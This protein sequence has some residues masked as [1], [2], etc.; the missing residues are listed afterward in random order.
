MPDRTR[1]RK[2]RPQH[3][4][5]EARLLPRDTVGRGLVVLRLPGVR[6]T[7]HDGYHPP[8]VFER[9]EPQLCK[10]IAQLEVEGIDRPLA[11]RPQL[12]QLQQLRR[13]YLQDPA[14]S[15]ER[16]QARLGRGA[17]QNAI[18]GGP[19]VPFAQATRH[20]GGSQPACVHDFFDGL[21]QRHVM[22]LSTRSTR[23]TPR[24]VS[25]LWY[26]LYCRISS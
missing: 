23:A 9:Q 15:D 25:H 4:N 6:N 8:L 17:I 16:T 18:E 13:A 1:R 2:A 12:G 19:V 3:L 7:A 11:M 22:L 24:W 5:E 14:Q 21:C 20:V 26:R 10:R